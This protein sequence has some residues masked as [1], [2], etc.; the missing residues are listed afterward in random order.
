MVI[1]RKGRQIICLPDSVRLPAGTRLVDITRQ[2]RALRLVPSQDSW[3][4][5]FEAAGVSADFMAR[6]EQPAADLRSDQD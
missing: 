6:R 5:W 1:D 3:A 2:G 4:E